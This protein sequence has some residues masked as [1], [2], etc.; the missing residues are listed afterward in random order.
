M[1]ADVCLLPQAAS[2]AKFRTP[3]LASSPVSPSRGETP[4]HRTLPCLP[5]FVGSFVLRM[6]TSGASRQHH[7][8]KSSNTPKSERFFLNFKFRKT[9]KRNK[10][11]FFSMK[12]FFIKSISYVWL[13][14]GGRRAVPGGKGGKGDDERKEERRAKRRQASRQAGNEARLLV[15]LRLRLVRLGV[16]VG[17]VDR[18]VVFFSF[19]GS[20]DRRAKPGR[21]HL[22]WAASAAL[23]SPRS[24]RPAAEEVDEAAIIQQ[25]ER[26]RER[27]CG[28]PPAASSRHVLLPGQTRRP[29]RAFPAAAS[30]REERGGGRGRE[31][32]ARLSQSSWPQTHLPPEERGGIPHLHCGDDLRFIFVHLCVGLRPQPVKGG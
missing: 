22:I 11:M 14:V 16:G 26:N 13:L 28:S 12:D 5:T 8:S 20:Q 30:A 18:S 24:R 21:Q 2:S 31:D 4:I 32:S 19:R 29:P 15:R 7:R 23:L 9:S 10:N 6:R 17:G 27:V 25:K 3:L 1:A